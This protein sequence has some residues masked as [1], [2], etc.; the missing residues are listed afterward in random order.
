MAGQN[1]LKSPLDHLHF[2]HATHL[3]IEAGD[4]DD[5]LNSNSKAVV[6]FGAS[7]QTEFYTDWFHLSNLKSSP[8]LSFCCAKYH[9][10]V[11]FIL[12]LGARFKM[13]Q[14]C[15]EAPRMDRTLLWSVC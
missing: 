14:A 8:D 5:N 4:C 15:L 1:N 9:R 12:A 11:G 7:T 13:K 2:H 3:Q 10:A 6:G